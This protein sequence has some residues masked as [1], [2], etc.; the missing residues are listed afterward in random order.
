MNIEDKIEKTGLRDLEGVEYAKL[1]IL[2]NERRKVITVGEDGF[3]ELVDC[4]LY[5]T[6]EKVNGEWVERVVVP[7]Q[8]DKIKFFAI[9]KFDEKYDMYESFYEKL[10]EEKDLD[11]IY[12]KDY[13]D[14]S[15][16]Y[17][18]NSKFIQELCKSG[19]TRSYIEDVYTRS[20]KL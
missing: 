11:K 3:Y 5:D 16:E 12:I 19:F 9:L 13:I 7:Q 6:H 2:C 10:E 14:N 4:D 1:A 18:I 15:N 17:D 8:I 20:S